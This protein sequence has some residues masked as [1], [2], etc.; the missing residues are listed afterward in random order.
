METF[1]AATLTQIEN[2][3]IQLQKKILQHDKKK[4]ADTIQQ[5]EKFKLKLFPANHLQE[6]HDNFIPYYIKYGDKFIDNLYQSFNPSAATL[7]VFTY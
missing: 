4:Q 5:I 3:L 6:R 1:T 7:K 2:Q